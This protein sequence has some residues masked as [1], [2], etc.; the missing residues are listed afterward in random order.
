MI[1]NL[2]F[3][4][5]PEVVRASEWVAI[6]WDAASPWNIVTDTDRVEYRWTL[7]AEQTASIVPLPGT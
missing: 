1:E 2:T 6:R 4:N 5:F 3:D 7:P